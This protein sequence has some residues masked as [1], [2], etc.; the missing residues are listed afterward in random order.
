MVRKILISISIV[1]IITFSLLVISEKIIGDNIARI[2]EKQKIA[3]Q[4]FFMN[5]FS[6]NHTIFLVGSS[7]V[8]RINA[9]WSGPH[10]VR[11]LFACFFVVLLVPLF[12]SH[13]PLFFKFDWRQISQR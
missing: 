3:E 1:F 7:H 10:K 12:V 6:E 4:N 11:T 9:T 13:L 5:N 2:F 8:G